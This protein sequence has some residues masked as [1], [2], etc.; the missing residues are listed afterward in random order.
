MNALSYIRRMT[1]RPWRLWLF[2]FLFLFPTIGN[3]MARI[4]KHGK[5]LND[6]DAIACG[7]H[8]LSLGQSPYSLAPVCAGLHPSAF[9]YAPQVA[10]LFVPFVNAFG[11][12]GSR[13]AYLVP[14]VPLTALVL[15]YMLA[16]AYPR[17]PWQFRLMTMAAIN[18]SAIIC[19]NIGFLLHGLVIAGALMIRR[20]RIPFIAAVALAAMVKPVFLTYLVVLAYED[21]KLWLRGATLA[22]G[23]VVGLAAV[24]LVMV[25]AGPLGPAWHASLSSVV[26]HDQ[27]GISFLALTSALGLGT[28]TPAALVLLAVY[29]VIM[30]LGGLVLAEWGGLTAQERVMVGI[31]IAQLVN[32]RLQDYDM[33]M[34]APFIAT[35]VMMSQP[36]GEKTF[37]WV[38]WIFAGV[39]I[40]GVLQNIFELRFLHRAPLTV[41]VYSLLT[42]YVAGRLAL[43]HQARIRALV[44]D[45]KALFAKAA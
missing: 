19:G 26:M 44:K 33:Y 42:L 10:A 18:G 25:T 22:A 45:P 6:Y 21:R 30:A 13:M 24:A 34:L 40:V 2:G 12:V 16:K 38:S 41:F 31:G 17:S 35:V 11:T 36:M 1:G 14:L 8:S 3:L 9:V 23:A 20:S 5:W 32:P 27:P 37:T 39:L 15:W 29:T 28:T 4:T 43:Q 7:A